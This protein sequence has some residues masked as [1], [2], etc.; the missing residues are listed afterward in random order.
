MQSELAEIKSE[1]RGHILPPNHPITRQI[2]GIVQAILD[3][4]NLGVVKSETGSMR[5]F[6]AFPGMF[7]GEDTWDP[8]SGAIDVRPEDGT[9]LESNT[10]EWE[11]I[12]VDDKK[13]VNA[14]ALP[15]K[16][17]NIYYLQTINLSTQGAII[18]FTG[19]LPVAQ[20]VQGLAAVLGHG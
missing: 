4:N 14:A 18:V 13:T 6:S 11:L 8:D 15:G 12:V 10:R 16:I 7:G 17:G 19:I 5:S 1:Y 9:H 20:D 3:A 2:R